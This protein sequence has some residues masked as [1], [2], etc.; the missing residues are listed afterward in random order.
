MS[1]KDSNEEIEEF[2]EENSEQSPGSAPEEGLEERAS[3]DELLKELNEA[4]AT[5]DEQME[6]VLRAR[7]EIE[8]IRRR[9]AEDVKKAHKY[10]NERFLKELVPV[11]DS[12]ERCLETKAE[13]GNELLNTIHEGVELTY[14]MFFQAL[15]K[16]GVEQ[17]NP[18]HEDFNPDLHEAMARDEAEK[19]VKS[20]SIIKVFQRG[21]ALS[22]RLIRPAL[23]VVAK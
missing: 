22:G 1:K 12:L 3:Y 19:G 18:L 8:N 15:E 16:I 10:G 23:V 21:Y 11:I 13:E 2:E 5:V 9:S 4:Q 20:G 7:A 6:T 14:Q 17:I